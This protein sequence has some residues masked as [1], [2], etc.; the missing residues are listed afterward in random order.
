MTEYKCEFF[1]LP[2]SRTSLHVPPLLTQKLNEH[3]KQGW[4]LIEM[5][6]ITTGYLLVWERRQ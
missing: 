2:V 3:A 6:E 1:N 4:R 5:P